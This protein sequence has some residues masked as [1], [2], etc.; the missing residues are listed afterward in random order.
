MLTRIFETHAHMDSPCY[1]GD[2]DAV[3]NKQKELGVNGIITS[4]SELPSSKRSVELADK[5]DFVYATVGIYPNES[6]NLPEDYIEQLRTMAKNSSKVV[7]IGEIG[8]DYGF[9]GHPDPAIQ[10]KCF[11]EQLELAIELD[12]PVVIHD[13]DADEDTLRIIKDYNIRGEIHRIFSPVEYANAFMEYGLYVA[14]GPQITY[15]NSE[16]LVEMVKTMPLDKLLLETDAPFLPPAALAG[17]DAYPDMISYV[18]EEI[19]RIRGDVT[20]QQ[21]LDIAYANAKALYGLN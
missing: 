13:R 8:M 12:L 1:A 17:Q 14:V 16:C 9:E 19:A 5:Y 10:E 18:A 4:G 6:A 21:V 11:R 20:A 15:P 3:M 7:A 2:L